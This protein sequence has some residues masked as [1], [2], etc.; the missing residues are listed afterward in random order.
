MVVPVHDGAEVLADALPAAAAALEDISERWELVV[1]DDGST[2][3]SPEIL[4]QHSEEDDRIRVLIQHGHR[5]RGLA[6]RR[7]FDAVRF[8][9]VGTADVTGCSSLG[10]LATMYPFLREAELVA[11]FR[12]RAGA[13]LLSWL[14]GRVL[15]LPARDV[16]CPL[17]LYRRSLLLML[18]L[19]EDGNLLDLEIFARAQR[20]GMRWAQVE[21]SGVGDGSD[22]SLSWSSLGGLL[23]LRRSL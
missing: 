22:H 13:R 3:S 8:L 17:R 5:G 9:V 15:G 18:D 19:C 1:V 7:G 6:L 14:A 4:R 2:D 12:R 10:E 16:N 20:A 21:V 23:R 11:G